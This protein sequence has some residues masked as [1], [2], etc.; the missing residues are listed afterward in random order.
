MTQCAFCSEVLSEVPKPSDRLIFSVCGACMNP[1]LLKYD[2][3]EWA[4]S[5]PKAFQDIRYVAQ[6]G[7][8]GAEILKLL[9]EAIERIPIL[10]EIAQRVLV[11]VRD[12]EVA[13]QDLIDFINQDQV[14]A[15][16]VLRLANSAM[17]GGLVEIKDLRSACARLGM[18]VIA[19]TVQAIANGRIYKTQNP[20]YHELME[21]LWRHAL[22]TAQCAYDI[23]LMIAEPCADMLFVAGL[24][25]DVG[26][27]LLLDLIGS[28]D[29]S[30]MKTL[31]E[32]QELF[33][34]VIDG[35]HTLV[36]LQICRRWNLPPEFGV[37]T[38]CHDRLPSV[39]DDS[40]LPPVHVIALASA[41]A[42]VSGFGTRDADISLLS[43]PS[44]KFLGLNDIKLSSLRID[45]E[46]KLETLIDATKE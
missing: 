5:T 14:I 36:G 35:Y 37:T 1:L 18:R 45:L 30:T 4:C 9:P 34:E 17:Y 32:S 24:V 8:I 38:F 31:R 26:K 6:E 40:W 7:S 11:M 19:N 39:P 20:I 21:Q 33:D 3:A 13:M 42:T 2:G 10:P 43:L 27:V 29:S 12:P 46:D 23:A 16:K 25:H 15:L 22:A 41:V 44:T 28:D